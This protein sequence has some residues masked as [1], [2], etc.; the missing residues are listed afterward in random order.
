[1]FSMFFVLMLMWH[2][3]LFRFSGCVS[4]VSSS[5]LWWFDCSHFS[6]RC[7][8]SHCN[9]IWFSRLNE[10]LERVGWRW[11]INCSRKVPMTGICSRWTS[12]WQQ[13]ADALNFI[14]FPSTHMEWAIQNT[15][16]KVQRTVT[17]FVIISS[18]ALCS[19]YVMLSHLH[20]HVQKFRSV[21]II[22]CFLHLWR[23]SRLV[24]ILQPSRQI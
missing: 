16:M 24:W 18:G 10:T 4:N 21:I 3:R 11:K 19:I 7:C 20:P 23:L 5:D 8:W 13:V 2:R 17:K 22:I 9:Y 12:A 14:T 1:M 6:G 15:V